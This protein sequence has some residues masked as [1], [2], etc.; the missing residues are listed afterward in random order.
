[1][2]NLIF[3]GITETEYEDK[4]NI[5]VQVVTAIA[6]TMSGED[7]EEKKTNAGKASIESVEWL[8]TYNP[9]RVR[10][11]KVKFGNKT[12]VDHPLKNKNK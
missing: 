3:Q 7:D 9:L 4:S 8:G 5:K 1:M 2:K 6:P 10:S 12:D 11:V